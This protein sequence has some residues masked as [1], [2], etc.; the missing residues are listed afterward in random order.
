MR[1][2]VTGMLESV[3]FTEGQLVKRGD[4]LA[5]ID[6]RTYQA[7]LDQATATLEKDQAHL[8]NAR[9]NLGRYEPLLKPGFS[10][11]MQVDTQRS[12]VLQMEST[13]KS[14]QAAI[15]AARTELSYTTIT[16]PFDGVTGIRL[17]DPGNIVHLN[18][19]TGIVVVTQLQPITV[20]FPLPSADIPDVQQALTHG[21]VKAEAYAADDKARLDDGK[22]LL[23]D[24]QADPATGTVRL[25]AVFPNAERQLWPGTFVNVHLAVRVQSDGLT[26]P[27]A[28]VQQG[29]A[30]PYAYLV[31]PDQT[32][33]VQPVTVGQ[34]RNGEVLVTKGLSAG[35][36]V[37]TAGQYR[38]T[39]GTRIAAMSGAAIAQVQ[40][41]TPASA[42]ML[43]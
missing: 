41:P 9:A 25:K 30:G 33:T 13:L 20:I 10:T 29:P 28:A 6:P 4:V 43:P 7:A 22:L 15:D 19:P 18:D 36:T 31:K 17:T 23:I 27:L 1:A 2:Q 35:E 21:E 42:G 5:R 32:V 11:E 8:A 14:D 3:E 26:V 40:S 12:E 38:L 34:S 39:Q 37:V 24:N 16:A